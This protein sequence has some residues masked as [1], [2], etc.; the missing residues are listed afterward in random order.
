VHRQKLKQLLLA[1]QPV[2]E[3]EK[4]ILKN[5]YQ[6]V[7]ENTECFSRKGKFEWK[8]K[9]AVCETISESRTIRFDEI[10]WLRFTRSL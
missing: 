7:D 6:F 8:T 4:N 5:F 10:L 1:Y 3:E 2:F 9:R